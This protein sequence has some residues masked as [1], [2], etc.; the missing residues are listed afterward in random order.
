MAARA[1][2]VDRRSRSARASGR[3]GREEI[4]RAA[5]EV[6]AARGFREASVDEIAERAGY[7]KGALYWHFPSKED[8][9][10][11]LL[12]E[13]VDAASREMVELL[14]SAPP[15]QDMSVEA[16]RR[17]VEL[18][19]SEPELLLLEH[20]YRSQAMRDSRVRRRYA[21]RQAAIREATAGALAAR[22]EH[23]G[24]PACD[25]ETERFATAILALAAGL[26][27]QRLI[28]PASVPDDLLGETIALI[29]RGL[30]A[31]DSERP[32]GEDS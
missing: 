28:D 17:F 30:V 6:V 15:E 23:L 12:E 31:R 26:A 13:R 2:R 24:T 21:Q 19:A 9:F 7:S 27:Q 11:A 8:L 32:P 25:R 4:L 1:E 29:Y 10:F 16:S 3:N 18:L 20:E 5:G 14:R 22:L